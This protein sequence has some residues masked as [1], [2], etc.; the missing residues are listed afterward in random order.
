MESPF[1]TGLAYGDRLYIN[2]AAL[3]SSS[4]N[5]SPN[6]LVSEN[7]AIAHEVVGHY[8]T[9]QKGTAFTTQYYD[10]TGAVKIDLH[11]LALDEAQASIRAGRFAPGLTDAER[12][13]L[14]KD[15]VARLRKQGLKVKDVRSL[16]DIQGR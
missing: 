16:L 2:N 4:P 6:P 1:E 12:L 7:G 9:V 11:N 13:A 5:G 10:S 15:G 14:I 8:E 3:P